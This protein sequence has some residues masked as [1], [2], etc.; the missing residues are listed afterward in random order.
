M[1]SVV[2]VLAAVAAGCGNAGRTAGR[3]CERLRTSAPI[4]DA[5]VASPAAA[6]TVVKEFE[7]LAGL[8]PFAIE[9]DWNALT[10]LVRTA[11]SMD[12]ADPSAQEALA[13]KVFATTQAA[14]SVVTYAHDRCQVDLSAAVPVAPTTTA[15]SPPTSGG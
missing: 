2:A 5:P 9:D 1:L 13:D 8:A 12:L 10:D 6:D 3:F 15:G 14:H 11:A 7:A 4:L